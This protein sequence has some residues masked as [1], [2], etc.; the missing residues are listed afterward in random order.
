MLAHTML[1]VDEFESV[2]R[3]ADKKRFTLKP[4]TAQKA[5]VITDLNQVEHKRYLDAVKEFLTPL[6][7]ELIWSQAS[8]TSQ[9]SVESLLEM[10][11][12]ENPDLICTYRNL[13]TEAWRWDFSLGVHLNALN[14]GTT[15]PV[16]VTP[17]P[18]TDA[19][20]SWKGNRLDNVLVATDHLTGDDELVN[21]GIKIT[22][23]QGTLHLLHIEPTEILDRYLDAIGKIPELDTDIA[24]E[25]IL[26]RLLHEP[27]D[28]IESCKEA[29]SKAEPHISLEGHIATGHRVS[30][31]R[32][33]INAQKADLLVFPTLEEDRIALHGVA[34]SLAVELVD[35]PLL[36]V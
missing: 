14:R 6:G 3:A 9:R 12:D 21:W 35:L 7:N 1:N 28:Y 26:E 13:Y 29:L 4:P 27:T 36:M 2:F 33:L 34:Y 31:Y 8:G 15:L 16:L 17:S 18:H 32:S 22:R 25:K 11:D 20:L 10:I 24:K 23:K 19:H 5:L 30:D